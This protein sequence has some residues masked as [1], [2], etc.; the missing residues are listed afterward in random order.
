MGPL[1]FWFVLIGLPVL[2]VCGF[3]FSRYLTD[4]RNTPHDEDGA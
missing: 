4:G 1:L 3:A 2:V